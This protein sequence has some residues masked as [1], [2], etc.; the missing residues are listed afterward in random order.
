MHIHHICIHFTDK[1]TRF[2]HHG[3]QYRFEQ[4]GLYIFNPQHED[5]WV[6]YPWTRIESIQQYHEQ[7]FVTTVIHP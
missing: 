5:I 6:F 2:I 1:T 3:E 4:Y 7:N